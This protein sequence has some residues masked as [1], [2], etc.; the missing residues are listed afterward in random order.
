MATKSILA[1]P[2]ADGGFAGRHVQCDGYPTARIFTL[3]YLVS[4]V[5]RG[6][7][8]AAAR[9]LLDEHPNG[10]V[11]LPRRGNP[12]ECYCHSG[13]QTDRIDMGLLTQEGTAGGQYEYAYVLHTDLLAIYE[14]NAE[15]TD[16]ILKRRIFW[17][18][19]QERPADSRRIQTRVCLEEILGPYDAT[20]DPT[21]R[22]NGWLAPS[23]T[24]DTVR[25]IA[26][27]TQQLAEED[28]HDSVD[29]IYVLD[30]GTRAGEPR[31]VVVHV[32]WQWHD[33]ENT[34]ASIIEPNDDGLYAIGGFSWC[35]G[36]ATWTCPC[37]AYAEWHKTT[38]GSCGLPRP[39]EA[40][41][42]LTDAEEGR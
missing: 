23:F 18:D 4:N 10:W 26:A 30:G 29:T 25:L 15:R 28:G 12:G 36:F 27:R 40:S 31:A 38:C 5:H 21:N 14:P 42:P 9:A 32:S 11:S 20:V 17:A 16:W 22:W 1:R 37:G 3:G 6:N 13:D 2:T 34:G 41:A 8:E 19:R 39:E 35:W 24:L 7:V 33:E